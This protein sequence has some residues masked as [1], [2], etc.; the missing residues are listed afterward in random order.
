MAGGLLRVRTRCAR[1]S[2]ASRL[3]ARPSHARPSYARFVAGPEACTASHV[4]RPNTNG[5][6]RQLCIRPTRMDLGHMLG[7]SRNPGIRIEAIAILHRFVAGNDSPALPD[8]PSERARSAA[9]G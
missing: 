3:H 4:L 9:L 6:A 7:G 2:S 1:L 5:L 8:I